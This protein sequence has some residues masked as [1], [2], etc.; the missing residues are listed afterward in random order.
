MARG[1]LPSSLTDVFFQELWVFIIYYIKKL[2]IFFLLESWGRAYHFLI[3][4][5]HV[6]INNR[7]SVFI[8]LGNTQVELDGLIVTPLI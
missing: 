1:E 4:E 8:S 3:L 6:E 7:S 2:H 5:T